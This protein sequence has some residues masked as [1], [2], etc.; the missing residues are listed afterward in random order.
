VRQRA[1][2]KTRSATELGGKLLGK[3]QSGK[4]GTLTTFR[5]MKRVA[6]SS[7][8]LAAATASKRR[9][10][11]SL[12]PLLERV[13]VS[14]RQFVAALIVMTFGFIVLFGACV[15]TKDYERHQVC[16]S[17]GYL[18]YSIAQDACLQEEG[19]MKIYVDYDFVLE[20]LS[21]G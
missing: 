21:N 7:A 10:A 19:V 18:Q 17:L 4:S 1:L 5:K 13:S 14:N 20:R 11:A 9:G 6:A 15:L 8:S 2:F 3:R 16:T 12:P